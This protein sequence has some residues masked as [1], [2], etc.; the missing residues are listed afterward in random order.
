[1][2]FISLLRSFL[3]R[4]SNPASGGPKVNWEKICFLEEEGGLGVINIEVWNK[5]AMVKHL[6]NLC[7]T[8]GLGVILF[9]HLGFT[10]EANLVITW[11]RNF[12]IN[13]LLCRSCCVLV[14]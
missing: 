14:G 4:G 5:A 8:L 13:K 1:M 9:G 7:S 10:L 12:H 3:W 2:K 11:S 6:W